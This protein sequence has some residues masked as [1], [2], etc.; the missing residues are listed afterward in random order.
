[1]T[2][3][4]ALL[5]A[6]LSTSLIGAP[7]IAQSAATPAASPATAAQSAHDRLFQLFKQSDEDSLKRNPITVIALVA[8]AS[9]PLQA[10]SRRVSCGCVVVSIVAPVASARRRGAPEHRQQRD[11]RPQTQ[12][13]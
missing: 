3:R 10:R 5:A 13:F 4:T 8:P 9:P 12:E 11:Q 7:A 2:I 6:L 1:M